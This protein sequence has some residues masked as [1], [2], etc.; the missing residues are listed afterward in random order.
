MFLDHD[1][2][3]YFDFQY[4]ETWWIPC[5]APGLNLDKYLFSPQCAGICFVSTS[6]Q[7]VIISLER[8]EMVCF[9]QTNKFCLL[10]GKNNL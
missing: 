7:T 9:Y 8:Q 5:V 4:L 10:L 1:I 3:A 6:V 2:L